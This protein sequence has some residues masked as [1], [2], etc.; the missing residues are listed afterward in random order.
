MDPEDKPVMEALAAFLRDEDGASTK[1]RHRPIQSLLY[2]AWCNSFSTGDLVIEPQ[3]RDV[4]IL[5]HRAFCH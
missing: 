5:L 3:F 4:R 1:D 2:W